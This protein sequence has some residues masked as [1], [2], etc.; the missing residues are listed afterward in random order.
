[1]VHVSSDNRGV[2][3]AD[4]LEHGLDIN[5]DHVDYF[6]DAMLLVAKIDSFQWASYMEVLFPF[7]A[8]KF[9]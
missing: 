3:V 4:G 8:K 1:M 7:Y 9:F 2:K 6:G 5:R